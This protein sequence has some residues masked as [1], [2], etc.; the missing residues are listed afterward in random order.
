MRP[1]V[2][3][4]ALLLGCNGA[5]AQNV[6]PAANVGDVYQ[7]DVEGHSSSQSADGGSGQS[8]SGFGL[9]ER[10]IAVRESGVELEFDLPDE[11]TADDR[12]RTWQYPARVLRSHPG[13]LQL[14]NGPE[15]ETRIGRWL[16]AAQI[17]RSACGRW[18]FTW[19][20]FQVQCDPQ[21]VIADLAPVDL[22]A[23][24]LRDGASYRDVDAL[25]STVLR[26]THSGPDGE[27]YVA[28]LQLNPEAVR[29]ERAESDVV[30]AQIMERETVSLESALAA[31]SSDRISGTI[32]VRFVV[33]P[34][35]HN[36]RRVKVR[37]VEIVEA[38]GNR[39]TTTSTET[40]V[41]RR[42][43]PRTR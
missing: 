12:A 29:R 17:P 24:E 42:V 37:Q 8:S 10:V 33:Q 41:R 26:R 18:Y 11:A 15:I 43:T 32:S 16:E 28:T 27:T 5:D 40:V 34:D 14:L 6:R 2:A 13:P 1:W 21:S 30:V 23:V 25:G 22:G 9:V 4:A 20:A 38:G 35:G 7:I 31:R 3:I 19:N 36:V 39:E